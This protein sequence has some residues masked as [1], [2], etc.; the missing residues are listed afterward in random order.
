MKNSPIKSVFF[1]AFDFETT[2]LYPLNDRII[3]IGA[4]KFN[5]KGSK[6]FFLS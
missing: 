6:K 2:G 1:T 3:E 4:V 5:F